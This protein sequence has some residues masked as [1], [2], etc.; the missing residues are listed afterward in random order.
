MSLH[1][2]VYIGSDGLLKF[3]YDDELAGLLELGASQI[4]RASHVEPTTLGWT[5]D[6]SPS[7]SFDVLGPFPRRTEALQA[8]VAWLDRQLA[9]REGEGS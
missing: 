3:V 7:G 1:F 4:R 8:E 9:S 2:T 6:L 5:A